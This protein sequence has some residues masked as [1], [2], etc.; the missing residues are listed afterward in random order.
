MK[1]RTAHLAILAIAS[2]TFLSGCSFSVGGP[3]TVSASDFEDTVEEALEDDG[4]FKADCGKDD[5]ELVEDDTVDCEV[6][7]RDTD[8]TYDA[9]VEITS[10]TDDR[11]KVSVDVD[12]DSAD[13]PVEDDSDDEEIDDETDTDTDTGSGVYVP[14]TDIADLASTALS[15]IIGFTPT[16]MICISEE[17]EIYVGNY[18][19]C[20]FTDPSDGTE[21]LVEVTID[22]FDSSTGEYHITA[23]VVG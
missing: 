16:D 4:N 14:G 19:Y 21:Y 11:Y 2:I 7:D 10:V 20:G 5:I 18:E 15:D 12:E 23:E 13:P 9:E 8:T 17:V 3:T 6:E 1:T 22:E